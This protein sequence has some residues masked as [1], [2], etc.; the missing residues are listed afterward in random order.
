MSL[1]NSEEQEIITKL[2]ILCHLLDSASQVMAEL[3]KL[4]EGHDTE[5]INSPE[6]KK[7]IIN[8]KDDKII[9][10]DVIIFGK[11][12]FVY[13]KNHVKIT[14]FFIFFSIFFWLAL[15]LFMRSATL[16]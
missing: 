5:E 14:L 11:R 4:V 3:G 7:Y 12:S 2:G 13:K 1:Y 15:C 10:T 16:L 6:Y 9:I 8:D